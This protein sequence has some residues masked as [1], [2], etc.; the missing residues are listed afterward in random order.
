MAACRV[1]CVSR[2][3]FS[4]GRLS[5]CLLCG[6][7][8]VA[9]YAAQQAHS[10][11]FNKVFFVQFEYNRPTRHWHFLFQNIVLHA[12]IHT[13]KD[14][15]MCWTEY[16]RKLL[17][18]LIIRRILTEKAWLSVG[19]KHAYVHFLKRSLGNGLGKLYTTCCN[20]LIIWVWL[21]IVGN[22]GT[23]NK[24]QLWEVLFHKYDHSKLEPTT[25]KRV[26]GLRF[27]T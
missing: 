14:W 15:Q 26:W 23:S 22:L 5:M 19:R 8:F 16:K 4:W 6:I 1:L 20:G 27:E 18:L 25:C 10:T 3:L 21:N 9:R 17:Y 24:E 7:A 13:Q 2:T 12:G 11:Y